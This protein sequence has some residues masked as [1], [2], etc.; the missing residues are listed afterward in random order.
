MTTALVIEDNED[1]M[2]LI[3]RL[4]KSAGYQTLEAMTGLAGLELAIAEQPDFILLD[5]QLPDIEGTEVVSRLRTTTEGKDIPVI[6]V[7]SYAMAGDRER[8]L[9][10]GCSG[11]IEKPINPMLVID[12]IKRI[13]GE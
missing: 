12:Q 8:L 7:T 5:I 9:A 10:A 6:A 4:L 11:Y 3:T 13:T 1:N 2:V